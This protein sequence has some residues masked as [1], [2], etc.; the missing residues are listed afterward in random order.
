MNSHKLIIWKAK[1]WTHKAPT[2]MA[3]WKVS[4]RRIHTHL[5]ETF[6]ILSA[7]WKRIQQKRKNRVNLN[8]NF[9]LICPT[10]DAPI[11]YTHAF[12]QVNL[13]Y[14]NWALNLHSNSLQ[15]H[16]REPH[17]VLLSIS[18]FN[19]CF[20]KLQTGPCIFGEYAY[21]PQGLLRKC[22]TALQ[23]FETFAK[24]SSFEITKKIQTQF[25][26]NKHGII[27]HPWL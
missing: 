14:A 11:L 20:E 2:K 16:E 6:H 8:G 27:N 7:F 4:S 10:F 22:I 26:V 17:V 15:M 12:T 24:S 1:G 23:H 19:S 18:A 9:F 21:G 25:Q 5:K 13:F 3:M